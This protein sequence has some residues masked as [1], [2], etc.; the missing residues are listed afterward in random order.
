[1]V[2]VEEET[3]AIKL[4]DNYVKRKEEIQCIW[5]KLGEQDMREQKNM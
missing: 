1:M 4:G 3:F 2:I 5:E